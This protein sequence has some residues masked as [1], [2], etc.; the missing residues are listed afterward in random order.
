MR[1]NTIDL[2]QIDVPFFDCCMVY[3]IHASLC[4]CRR[5]TENRVLGSLVYREIMLFVQ[6]MY[7]L[8][9]MRYQGLMSIG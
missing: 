6:P 7:M 1:H 8:V 4:R 5:Y 3:A 2:Y 9:C